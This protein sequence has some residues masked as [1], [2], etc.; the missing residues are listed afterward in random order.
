MSLSSDL[1]VGQQPRCILIG[2]YP[3]MAQLGKDMRT[4]FRC[5]PTEQ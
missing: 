4:A 2:D 1:V 5:I 3:R